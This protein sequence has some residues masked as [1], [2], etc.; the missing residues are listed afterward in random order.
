MLLDKIK[1]LSVGDVHLGH[2]KTPAKFILDNLRKAFVD[3]DTFA[4][5]DL[6]VI[7]GDFFDRL[8]QLPDPNVIEIRNWINKILRMCKK[9]NVILRVLEGTPSHDW[10]QSRLFTHIN[11]LARIGTDV[12]YVD[13][14]SI[15]FITPLGISVLYLP[16][17]WNPV[18]DDTWTE[19]SLALSSNNLTQVDI[20]V[21]HG[22]FHYQLPEHIN[23]PATHDPER[24]QSI[25]KY[26]IFI[27]HVHKHTENN[28]IIAAGSFDRLTH[29]EEEPK[30]WI[31]ATLYK[32]GRKET[33]FIENTGARVY[34][35]IDC[36][37]LDIDVALDSIERVLSKLPEDSEVRIA[38]QKSD[39]IV[40]SLGTLKLKYPQFRFS[41]VKI[42]SVQSKDV[43]RIV[44]LRSVYQPINITK[45][46][47][48]QLLLERV[49]TPGIPIT[50]FEDLL[51]SLI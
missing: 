14:L 36:S 15:E 34:K 30:G 8:L 18:A 16:D 7:P 41:P 39:S 5:Y 47:I 31:S 20:C 27:G 43:E 25:V 3:N 48:T 2:N 35:T 46:N 24:Y 44:D 29:G 4:S 10:K 13:T 1:I 19:V 37:G 9:H 12:R 6:M 22:A 51:R 40:A 26:Y 21:M 32:D 38:A 45:D 42:T 50:K 23:S 49:Q 28:K 11:E 17:E 33:V